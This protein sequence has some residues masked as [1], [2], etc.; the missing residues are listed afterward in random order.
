MLKRILIFLLL[1]FTS[2]AQN[3]ATDNASWWP[4]QK[5]P[6]SISVCN[7]SNQEDVTEL[8]LAQSLA[9]LAAQAINEGLAA[10]AVWITTPLK[11][12]AIYYA[13]LV[14]RLK[15][16]KAGEYNVWQLA[17]RYQ[18]T[19]VIKG[20]VLYDFKRL[21]NSVN[22]A[23]SFAAL[24]KGLLVDLSQEAMAKSRGFKKLAD[25]SR[26]DLSP[27]LFDSL[28][29]FSN[30]SLLV[31]ANP[32]SSNN[33]DYAIAHK[34][35]VYY[36]VDSIFQSIIN[37][38][39]PISPVIGWNKGD[40]SGHI[41][42]CSKRGLINTA[43]DW[44]MNLAVL[45][46][47]GNETIKKIKGTDPHKINW[48]Q[49]TNYHS[50]LMSDGDNMQWSMGA[51]LSSP[52]FWKN[53][54]NEELSMSFTSC[55]LNLA[56]GAGDAY[57]LLARTQP[58]NGS[59]VEYGGGY[60][61][62]DLFA[63]ETANPEKVLRAYA[64][65]I[66]TQMKKTGTRVFGFICKNVSGEA[67]QKAYQVYAEELEDITGMIA[68][69]YSPYNG[70]HGKIFWVKNKKGISIPVL[71]AR[72][73]LWA[74]L[75]KNGSGNPAVIARQINEDAEKSGNGHYALNCTVVHAWSRFIRDSS[76][77]ITDAPKKAGNSVRGVTPVKWTKELLNSS[78]TLVSVEELLWRI[79][80][81]HN[82]E[83]TKAVIAGIK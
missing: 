45:S 61:Y 49:K 62:P 59:V 44:C 30:A 48:K 3:A 13:S 56:Q 34:S 21:D 69:Q 74:N 53:K 22:A 6:A 70:G 82:E 14:K 71:T 40:E 81:E 72:Y 65:G 36:G 25:L 80:M 68:I 52:E 33:R 5:A 26:R 4:L 67:A 19:G 83:E 8:N 10:E 60:Y 66:N 55:V 63:S 9:G 16:K 31:I 20:Y 28:R 15:L 43:S 18:K 35:I 27:S 78:T 75:T 24:T 32:V 7:I 57:E 79:R 64:A 46:A 38:V 23:T 17:E 39:K 11:D 29:I 50:F 54:Y 37:W 51:F 58:G 73:Q 41:A 12:Y 47:G 42:P 2:A 76:G 1:P 77:L